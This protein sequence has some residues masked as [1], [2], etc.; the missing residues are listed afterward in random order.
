[1][2]RFPTSRHVTARRA[3]AFLACSLLAACD[4]T[5]GPS[6]DAGLPDVS[7]YEGSFL[8]GVCAQTG[9]GSSG[10]FEITVT[11][12][13]ANTVTYGHTVVQYAGLDCEGTGTR[14]D[15]S[16]P[17]GTVVFQ[18]TEGNARIAFNRGLWTTP[19]AMMNR[20]IWAFET[21]DRICIFSDTDP[22]AFPSASSVEDYLDVLSDDTCYTRR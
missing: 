8:Q 9:G 12:E 16:T 15:S 6:G 2:M 10:R 7:A 13:S 22:T 4:D 3:T 5:A 1:M 17:L 21:P 11:R 14:V 18:P 20:V 19:S